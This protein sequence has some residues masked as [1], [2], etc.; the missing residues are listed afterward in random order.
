MKNQI[1]KPTSYKL[2][3]Q[4]YTQQMRLNWRSAL[5]AIILP[6][7][8]IIFISFIPTFLVAKL[9]T[10]IIEQPNLE[11]DTLFL[12]ISL[13]G[14]AWLAGE[15]L[16]R[17]A[18]LFEAHAVGE[19]IDNLYNNAMKHLLNKDMDF[20]NN[21]FAGSLTKNV[22]GYARSYERFF[23]TIAFSISPNIIP[24]SFAAVVLAFYSPYISLLLVVMLVMTSVIVTPLIQKRRA[25]VSV[26]EY[27]ST[28]LIGHVAD[29]IGN[30]PA[31]RSFANESRELE[32]HGKNVDEFVTKARRSWFYQI[33]VVDMVISPLYVLTNILGLSL[34]IYIGNSKGE[35]S[36]EA[37]LVTFGFFA[38]ATRALFDFNQVYRDLETSLSEGAQFTDY[39]LDKPVIVDHSEKKLLVRNATIDFKNVNFSYEEDMDKLIFAHF[40]L[41]IKSGEHIGLVGRSGS[42]K[43][44]ITK[45]MLRFMEVNDGIISIDGHDINKVTQA[46]LRQAISYVPQ[47]P[48]LFHRSLA[49]NIR[50]SNPDATIESVKKAAK[51]AHAHEFI[52]KL[53]LGYNT[54]VGERGIKLS[55]GQRQRIAI[56]R[57]MLKDAPILLLD[58]ATSALDSESEKLIQDALWKLMEGKTTIVIAHR[59]STIQKMDR[60]L[61]LDDGKILEDGNHKAL[62]AKKGVYAALWKHQSGGFLE[63]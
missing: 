19:G 35:L 23:G 59:L 61:V 38:T 62:I 54:L 31:V 27:A 7:I 33:K 9:V 4:H 21:N 53:P 28:H 47:D 41:N 56:A 20:F 6:G 1:K 26:R 34:V 60:I 22:G 43:T 16:W 30:A 14:L 3:Y 25:L 13:I 45:L 15:M 5:P 24:I 40:N 52:E 58:E 46:S 37:I 57:A 39:L 17:I 8:G 18:F 2:A 63:D 49:D 11:A 50:Y 42:G 36:T 32:T 51:L 12:Y 48:A 10:K 55:G 29:V 44:T